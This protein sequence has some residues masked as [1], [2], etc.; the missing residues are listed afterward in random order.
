MTREL[1][2]RDLLGIAGA[3]GSVALAGCGGVLGDK[4]GVPGTPGN[5]SGDGGGNGG[6]GSQV[7]EGVPEAVHTW[8]M[9]G[10]GGQAAKL[11]SDDPSAADLTGQDSA[12]IEV[13][14]GGQGVAFAPAVAIVS[15]GTEVTWEWTGNGGAHNVVT[16]INSSS[17][18]V[19]IELNSGSAQAGSDVTYSYTFENTGVAPYVCVPHRAIGMMGAVVVQE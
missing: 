10:D 4:R 3:A 6:G 14:A 9:E 13:G 11:Y 5:G 1:T 19:D 7:P 15:T 12:T 2:R 16:D 17:V 8:M 18:P